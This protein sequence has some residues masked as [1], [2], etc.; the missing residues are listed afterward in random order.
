[1]AE[2]KNLDL[3][4]P[5]AHS[6]KLLGKDI[7]LSFMPCGI[8][9]D[10]ND[11]V[12]ELAVLTTDKTDELAEG[13]RIAR[14]AFELTVKL[15]AIVTESQYPELTAEYLQNHMSIR[16]LESFA[17]EIRGLLDRELAAVGGDAEGKNAETV[18]E[19]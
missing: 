16:Q 12:N 3:L 11:V 1:V 15:C 19:N 7:D 10:I 14:K 6:I 13:G 8:V 2:I 17:G 4:K 5:E 18:K 9:F